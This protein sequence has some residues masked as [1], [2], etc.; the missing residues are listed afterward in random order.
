MPEQK[1]QQLDWIN[2]L[3]IIAMFFVIVLHTTSPLLMAYGKVRDSYWLIADFFN[4]LSRFGVPVFVMITGALL[5]NRDYQLGDFLRKRLGRI[6]P[7]FIFWSG[8]YILYSW[9]N[10]DITFTNNISANIT[11]VLH[12]FKY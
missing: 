1:Q 6:F 4:A 12:Q 2:N 3:R 8:V 9:Y 11:L 10:E 7:P 5:L